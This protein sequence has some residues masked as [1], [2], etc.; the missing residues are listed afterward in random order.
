MVP[1]EDNAPGRATGRAREDAMGRKDSKRR[2]L[3]QR[4]PRIQPGAAPGT[5][6]VD[7]GAPCPVINVTGYSPER[8]TETRIDDL[9]DLHRH[10]EGWPVVWV[11]VDGLG[12]EEVIREI[13]SG[14]GIHR[15]AMED[16]FNV[17][18]RA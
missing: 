9:G 17:P 10:L 11:N 12:D 13:A 7:P 18:Q 16:V 6:T 4:V 14:F 1:M 8:V 2:F 15:L 3:R 5:I